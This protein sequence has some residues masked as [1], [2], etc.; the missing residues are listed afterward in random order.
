M[1]ENVKVAMLC[2]NS[3]KLLNTLVL[4][5]LLSRF[6]NETAH[7]KLYFADAIAK[8]VEYMVGLQL[9]FKLRGNELKLFWGH[10]YKTPGD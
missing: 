6:F 8:Q 3:N 10:L 7:I 5:P 4:S 2:N 1:I 9:Y